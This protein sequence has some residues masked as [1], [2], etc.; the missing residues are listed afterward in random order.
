[1]RAF[2]TS[3]FFRTFSLVFLLSGLLAGTSTAA[4]AASPAQPLINDAQRLLQQ[5]DAQAAFDLL[6]EQ[7]A[8][9][10][11]DPEFDYWLGLT[12]VRS[13]NP[14]LALFALE[15]VV[16]QRPGHAAARLELVGAYIQLGQDENAATELDELAQLNPPPRAREAI[17]QYRDILAARGA[18]RTGRGIQGF[19]TL[20]VGHDDN[21]GSWP[22][23]FR[24]FDVED[25]LEAE[26][27]VYGSLQAGVRG[28]MDVAEGRQFIAGTLSGM[29]RRNQDEET[30][31]FNMDLLQLQ[32]EWGFRLDSRRKIV[33]LAEVGQLKLDGEDYRTHTGLFGEWRH[34]LDRERRYRLRLGA[35][36]QDFEVD[37]NDFLQ[38]SINALYQHQFAPTW[39][40]D[41]E[42]G[43]DQEDADELRGGGDA[44]RYFVRGR[45][46][47]Q[48]RPQHR[49]SGDLRIAGARFDEEQLDIGSLSG[50]T[51]TRSDNSYTVG[52]QW[53]WFPAPEWQL[54]SRVQYRD[55]SSNFDLYEFSQTQVN[56]ALSRYF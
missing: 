48:L 52:A 1:M 46:V 21:P 49:L 17:A 12:G 4:L 36:D 8:T 28:Q 38:L 34:Q 42:L 27:T 24:L 19:V 32:G 53:E 9:Y 10:A 6:S 56:L 50:D 25:P 22:D 54:R 11:G 37:S 43:I 23:D 20:E 2:Y 16:A 18:E 45:L 55:Q 29:A 35:R 39:R 7:E 15:R 3:T 40:A 31:Q 41:A 51:D 44:T 47:H 33:A 30:E 14:S 26:E 5:G 13:G